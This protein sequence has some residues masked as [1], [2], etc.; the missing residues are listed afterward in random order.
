MADRPGMESLGT[1]NP[2]AAQ[3]YAGRSTRAD[4]AREAGVSESTVSRAL[5]NN[6]LISPRVRERVRRVADQLGYIPNRAAAMLAAAR[7]KRLGLVINSSSQSTFR[8][9]P[10][11]RSYFP[12]LLD[13]VLLR[14]EERGF[15]VEVLLDKKK[16]RPKDLSSLIHAR[17]VDGFIFSVTPLEDPRFIPLRDKAIPFVLV[18]NY[19]EGMPCL[20]GDPLPGMTAAFELCLRKGFRRIGYVTGDP[21][22]YDGRTRREAFDRLVDRFG[23]ESLI[24]QGDF[25][26]T[27]GYESGFFF[28]E[29]NRRAKPDV[30]MTASD[31]SALGLL[32]YCRER[33]IAV[34][35]D[36]AL[37]GYDDLGPARDSYPSLTTVKNPVKE[38]GAA[39]VDRLITILKDEAG[40]DPSLCLATQLIERDST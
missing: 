24:Y 38:L 32:H 34:P 39:A 19:R 10:F 27:C 6:P 1:P 9:G 21:A 28:F 25:S 2:F 33:R 8:S 31:R 12:R 18:N 30:I 40:P 17:E 13:G 22:Y 3:R 15:S 37:I 35:G 36:V 26:K 4:V 14:A 5:N 11:T 23:L 16:G 20:N 29:S 7:T